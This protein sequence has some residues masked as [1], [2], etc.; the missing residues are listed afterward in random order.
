MKPA[1]TLAASQAFGAIGYCRVSTESQ[2]RDDRTSLADQRRAID[3]LAARLG[4]TLEDAALFVDAG[5]SGADAE[6]R[7]AFMRLVSYCETHRRAM[8][9]PG[10]VLVL[11]DSRF[12]RFRDPDEA[13]AWRYRLKQHGWI[14]RFAESDDT[15][16]P[17][18][19]SVLRAV[20]AAQASEYRANISRN[21]KRGA[22]GA[23]QQGYWLNE[24]PLGYRRLATRNGKDPVV[25][26]PGQ[27]KADDQKVR[28][29]PGPAIEQELV[30]FLYTSYAS[31]E[32][33]LG[34]LKRFMR[35]PSN[36]YASIRR[37]WSNGTLRAILVNRTYVGDVIWCRRPHDKIERME[38]R[39]RDRD[40]WVIAPDAHPPLISRELFNTVARRL[41]ANAKQVRR[42][43]GAYALTGLLTCAQCGSPYVGG[44]GP[45]NKKDPTDPDR[46]RFYK[47]SGGMNDRSLCA[48]RLGTLQ[49]RFIEPAVIDVIAQEVQKPAVASAIA[50]E[51][52][53]ALESMADTK[54]SER[55]RLARERDK[56][57]AERE[58]VVRAVARGVL[59]DVEARATLTDLR[60][61]I[62]AASTALEQT[63][64]SQRAQTTLASERDRLLKVAQDFGATVRAL[65]PAAQR[66]LIRPWL[67]NA[68][69]DKEKRQV[70]LTIRRVPAVGGS[71]LLSSSPRPIGK[72]T[73][74]PSTSRSR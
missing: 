34:R 7:P 74:P 57:V 28:L 46:Y 52:D 6:G 70:V 33:T 22:R 47:D 2:A 58:A 39:V 65:S 54:A 20:G 19:R 72:K 23:A 5:A 59:T 17:I 45:K 18:G 51:L 37:H 16:D 42:P 4:V 12:G 13:A 15:A 3:A 30:R 41:S 40:Q 31:G 64:F 43:D 8:R 55:A 63:M 10:F 36:P 9:A 25:L 14:V 1:V 66:E 27:R 35:D 38:T 49:R 56:L 60:A 21:A 11:N 73:G 24:A 29:T 67:A 71:L 32:W 48:G 50:E 26:D 44:G 53:R 68:V 62:D 69:V 61:R